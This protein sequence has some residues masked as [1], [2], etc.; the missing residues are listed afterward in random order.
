MRD[1]R[2]GMEGR[3]G[4]S[5]TVMESGV[6]GSLSVHPGKRGM[7]AAN[8]EAAGS[9]RWWVREGGDPGAEAVFPLDAF[10]ARAG[11]ALPRFEE[12][13]G[14]DVP[15]PWRT[16]LVHERDMTPTLESHY[17]GDIHIEVLG[18]ERVGDAYFRE[19]IL[20]LDRDESP[21]EFGANRIALDRL[22][23]VVRRLVLQEQLPLGHIL[24]AHDVAHTGRP[25]AFFRVEADALMARA[26]GVAVGRSL[27]GR[28]NTLRDMEGRA[29]SEVVEILPPC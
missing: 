11:L 25:S 17:Q 26:L 29:L 23:T 28:R 6:P 27:Y 12:L 13:Q 24:K 9:G 4:E 7:T 5:V 15:E 3:Q 20:R 8:H 18:R 19:V 16:L 1:T 14:A 21:V 22:P 10:Y 2:D